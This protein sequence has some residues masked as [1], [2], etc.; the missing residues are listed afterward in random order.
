L[1]HPWM[2]A[3]AS[4]YSAVTQLGWFTL[5][6][7]HIPTY[8]TYTA[9]DMTT[10]DEAKLFSFVGWDIIIY[11]VVI[12]A[13]GYGILRFRT[14]SRDER[15][16]YL[17]VATAILLSSLAAAFSEPA[18]RYEARVIWLLPMTFLANRR[19]WS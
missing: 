13:L 15:D 18:P 11:A 6:D 9:T 3:K 8:T 7:Y 16:L 1:D 19:L 17:L 5:D 2:Q 4:L 12:V 14:F 10:V